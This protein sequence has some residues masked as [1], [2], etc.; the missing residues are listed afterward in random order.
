MQTS[1]RT[2]LKMLIAGGA[3][4]TFGGTAQ[5]VLSANT[6]PLKI[7]PLDAGKMKTGVRH[8]DLRMGRSSSDFFSNLKTPTYGINGSYL[9]PTIKLRNGESVQLNVHN[10]I[11]ETST[12]HWH[13]LHLP[14]SA[15]GG[16]HQQIEHGENWQAKFDV[17]QHAA[18]FWYH[19]HMMHK[20]GFQVYH[21]L[22]GMI[23]V[24]DES[25]GNRGLPQDY[26]IDDIPVIL[27]DRRFN[28]DGTLQYLSSMHD[29]MMGMHGDNLLVN[30]TDNPHLTARTNTLR[31]RLLNGSNA[32]IYKLS[33]NDGRQFQKIATD[34]GLLERPVATNNIILAPAERAEIIVD[35]SDG[36]PVS[37]VS[38]T[39]TQ[40]GMMGRMMGDSTKFT[41]LDIIPEE[42]R[43]PAIQLP[44]KLLT[45]P[46]PD[47]DKAVRTR[48]FE[49]NMG[50]GMGMMMR[51]GRAAMTINGKS[52]DMNRIDEV[53][54]LGTQEIWVIDNPTMLSHPFHIH[55]VQFRIL[56]RN[57]SMPSDLEAG[58]KDT[59]LVRPNERV[60]VL[61]GFADYADPDRPYMYHCHILEHED[62][63]M[64][65]QFTVVS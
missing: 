51:R 19:S 21:G 36:K 42:N 56:D 23:I 57:G 35:V 5:T 8:F 2:T 58:F 31:L 7:P 28:R 12:L 40:G 18:T 63:G 10:T 65:G 25:T 14:A 41:V 37:L 46:T 38:N 55:D 44:E 32:R 27:Q 48:Q 29:S 30:G 17:K 22:A 24:E 15:D 61:L 13:G 1:R 11:G 52:M 20:T 43:R 16:P 54:K 53:V 4:A 33:F 49:L 47:S 26:G 59:V 64:M 6:Q 3:A 39:P 9:G 62:A 50:M 45:L 60:R 34:G